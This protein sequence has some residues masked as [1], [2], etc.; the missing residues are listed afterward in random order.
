MAEISILVAVL[1]SAALTFLLRLAPFVALQKLGDSPLV[2]HLA[3]TMPLGVMVI[4]VCYTLAETDV[5]TAPF[6]IPEALCLGLTLALHV[7]RGNALLSLAVGT[8]AYVGLT[9]LL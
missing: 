8:G 4:L 5:T 6:G 3:S 1:V 2:E 9:A 7:W